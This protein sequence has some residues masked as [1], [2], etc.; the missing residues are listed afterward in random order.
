MRTNAPDLYDLLD[1][2]LGVWFRA[3]YQNPVEEIHRKTVGTSDFRPSYAH[4]PAIGR[5]DNQWREFILQCAIEERKT[6]DV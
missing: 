3:D 5:H 6:L 1:V 4:H 2:L